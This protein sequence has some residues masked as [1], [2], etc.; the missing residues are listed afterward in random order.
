MTTL[1][2]ENFSAIRNS[3]IFNSQKNNIKRLKNRLIEYSKILLK[4]NVVL[5]IPT[6][7]TEL[8]LVCSFVSLVIFLIKLR[9]QT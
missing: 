3:K 5:G 1:A 9:M 4:Y 8:V 6:P 7:A 2:S